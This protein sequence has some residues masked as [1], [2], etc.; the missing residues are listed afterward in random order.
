[1]TLTSGRIMRRCPPT[2]GRTQRLARCI[3]LGFQFVGELVEL[4]DIYPGPEPERVRNGFRRRVPTRLRLRAEAG[5]E[6][7][8]DHVLE[9]QPELAS[10]PLQETGQVVV[11]GEC[12]AHKDIMAAAA[13][14]VKASRSRCARR[15]PTGQ[16]ASRRL[17]SIR[18]CGSATC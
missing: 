6:R 4:V 9:R 13:F 5:A 10:T 11:D 1:M 15:R 16:L 18:G 8:V 12:G 7:P 17:R 2:P 3:R 14:D